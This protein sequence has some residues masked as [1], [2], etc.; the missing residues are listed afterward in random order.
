MFIN[1]LI[2]VAF[3]SLIYRKNS[4]IFSIIA[5]TISVFVLFGIDHIRKSAKESFN[6]TISGIDLIVGP[7][8]SELNLLLTTVFRLGVPTHNMSWESYQ[9]LLHNESI[10][11][12]IPIALGDSHRGYRVVGTESNFFDHYKYGRSRDIEF[13]NGQ[14][15]VTDF[16]VVLGA[17][18]AENLGYS[19]KEKLI[20]SHGVAE[21]SFQNHDAFPFTITGILKP[22]GTPID[23]AL[24]VSLS[25]L[26]TI[27]S[28]KTKSHP[29]SITATFIG[30]NTKLM[31]FKVQREINTT[32]EEALSAILPGV[33]LTQLW[34]ITQGLENTLQLIS[35]MVLVASMLGLSS[36]LLATVRERKAELRILRS[37]GAGPLT[38][39]LLV[40]IEAIGITLIGTIVAMIGLLIT[41]MVSSDWIMFR[42]GVDLSINSISA[43]TLIL[44]VYVM[45]GAL[46]V[47]SLPAVFSYRE[48]KND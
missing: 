25:G 41:L 45:L 26:E 31:T 16:D 19:L 29:E 40:Q 30:L 15:F 28:G 47:G 35:S 14:A 21:I 46:G 9:R 32:R 38:I 12:A 34:Q 44:F 20:I 1:S 13:S 17:H 4:V 48:I 6:G 2:K 22:T 10:D 11:W 39:F 7:R 24:Y 8:T 5:I 33:A 36:V 42:Y 43:D 18:V 37:L 23:N 3:K 27:H